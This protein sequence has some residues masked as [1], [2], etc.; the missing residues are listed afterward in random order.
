PG[1]RHV[2]APR[3][4]KFLQAPE[5]LP[6]GRADPHQHA[7]HVTLRIEATDKNA[8]FRRQA[9]TC[10][11]VGG[12]AVQKSRCRS[13]PDSSRNGSHRL[14]YVSGVAA[15]DLAFL[16][17]PPDPIFNVPPIVTVCLALFVLVHV[18]R[19]F[20]LSPEADIKFLL[21]FSF[22]PAR[23]EATP[24]VDGALPGGVAA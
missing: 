10:R 15:T 4:A 13:R 2:R 12:A 7:G 5:H 20:V 1:T 23:Y 18:I 14:L 21:L 9:F 19:S 16:R 3:G 11:Y 24:L 8:I 17:S 6:C 22:I